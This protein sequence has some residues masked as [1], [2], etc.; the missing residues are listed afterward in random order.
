MASQSCPDGAELCRRIEA[1]DTGMALATD[2]GTSFGLSWKESCVYSL[3][4]AQADESLSAMN[5]D[6]WWSA[7]PGFWV[8]AG[9]PGQAT[10]AFRFPDCTPVQST[11]F[12]HA[13]VYLLDEQGYGSD[14]AV[15]WTLAPEAL[16]S[17]VG[18][19]VIAMEAN[20]ATAN[21]ATAGTNHSL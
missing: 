14:R 6:F 19:L 2:A 5:I 20:W 7:R 9:Y 18:E 16:A 12:P 4:E 1:G 21:L 10:P 11:T 15:T 8:D 17:S 3:E 13:L